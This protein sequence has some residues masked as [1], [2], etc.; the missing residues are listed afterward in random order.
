MMKQ[1]QK[2]EDKDIRG[3]VYALS[4]A[5]DVE[6]ELRRSVEMIVYVLSFVREGGRTAKPVE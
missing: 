1:K 5:I 6:N 2:Q 4:Q 3:N